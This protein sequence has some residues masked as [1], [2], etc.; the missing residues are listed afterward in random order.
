MRTGLQHGHEVVQKRGH[1]QWIQQDRLHHQRRRL[2]GRQ[3]RIAFNEALD[4]VALD[5]VA[6]DLVIHRLANRA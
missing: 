5:L 1:F 3:R 6:L 4:F 2:H